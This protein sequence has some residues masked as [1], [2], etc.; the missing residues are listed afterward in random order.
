MSAQSESAIAVVGGGGKY[1]GARG[2]ARC[3]VAMSDE[4]APLY[5]YHVS[6][7]A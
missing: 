1:A 2:Q 5:R 4:N 7:E 3:V 6:I